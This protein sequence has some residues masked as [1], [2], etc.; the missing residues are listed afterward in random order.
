MRPI[1]QPRRLTGAPPPVEQPAGATGGEGP[2]VKLDEGVVAVIVV[3]LGNFPLPTPNPSANA[4][5][6]VLPDSTMVFLAL[7]F[8][9]LLL[10]CVEDSVK[11]RPAPLH[12]H[13][14]RNVTCQHPA[15][16]AELQMSLP[17]SRPFTIRVADGDSNGR[18]CRKGKVKAAAGHAAAG[19]QRPGR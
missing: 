14:G 8:I 12:E 19:Q 9:R 6:A 11:V 17:V 15:F 10:I 7:G 3:V 1:M 2:A 4:S 5:I 18:G 16:L 13:G